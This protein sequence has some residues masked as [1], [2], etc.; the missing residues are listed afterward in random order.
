METHDD[1]WRSLESL[2]A[3][4]SGWYCPGCQQQVRAGDGHLCNLGIAAQQANPQAQQSQRPLQLDGYICGFCRTVVR[5][6]GHTCPEGTKVLGDKQAETQER[7][8]AFRAAAMGEAYQE[9]WKE[10]QNPRSPSRP[11]SAGWTPHKCPVCEG[12]GKVQYDPVDPFRV[13]NA[14]LSQPSNWPCK[15]CAGTGVLWG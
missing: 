11:P 1:I 13:N 10:A 14:L 3:G 12:I 2:K 8:A 6:S 4:A 5:G 15:A 7:D 9:W